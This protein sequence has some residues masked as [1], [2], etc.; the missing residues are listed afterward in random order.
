MRKEKDNTEDTMDLTGKERK[1]KRAGALIC[2]YCV[3]ITAVL[4]VFILYV[5]KVVLREE[6]TA[7]V[8]IAAKDIEKGVLIDET[9]AAQYFTNVSRAVDILPDNCVT[10]LALVC[11]M[12]TT[13]DY[14]AKDIITMSGFTS[15]ADKT[16]DIINP[17]E[18]SIATS[19]LAQAVGGILRT[20]D[21]INIWSISETGVNGISEV[22]ATQICEH[23]YVSKAFNSSGVQLLRGADVE[24][25]TATVISII[26]SAD[27][28]ED[29][30]VALTQGTIRLA[31]CMYDE[32]QVVVSENKDVSNNGQTELPK[33]DFEVGPVY[34][35]IPEYTAEQLS[36]WQEAQINT[37]GYYQ[38]EFGN[39]MYSEDYDFSEY[40]NVLTGE[41]TLGGYIY[42]AE[43]MD[44]GNWYIPA[45]VNA[46]LVKE[47]EADAASEDTI[48]VEE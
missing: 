43:L 2:L 22:T 37:T 23:V 40:Y 21:Y 48:V 7:N 10:D 4:Y 32:R 38:D 13:K 18:V 39:L 12:F 47:K 36:F 19:T 14:V 27:D 41:I 28:E 9:N 20:G 33:G 31:L 8:Y 30:N 25:G 46:A 34:M 35:E 3:I 26:L 15:E 17:V 11:N 24:N 5:E 42:K 1:R 29:F 6:P 16:A 44:D 45:S